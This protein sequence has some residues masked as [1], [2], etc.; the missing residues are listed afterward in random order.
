MSY[1]S[2]EMKRSLKNKRFY[3]AL[4]LNFLCLL[5]SIW[6]MRVTISIDKGYSLFYS[7]ITL[8]SFT[9]ITLLAPVIAALPFSGSFLQD[10]DHQFIRGVFGRMKPSKYYWN[11]IVSTGISGFLAIV[12]PLV[13]LLIIN[14]LIFGNHH[15]NVGSFSGPFSHLYIK[16]QDLAYIICLILN[17]GLFGFVYANL[18]LVTSLFVP[19]T[20]ATIG[21]PLIIYMIP[22]FFFTY[23]G[24][25]RFEP[26]TTFYLSANAYETYL[27]VYGQLLL[28]EIITLG[29]GY[30]RI[31]ETRI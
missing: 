30:I 29:A 23:F 17:S 1:F 22:S 14:I 5:I 19:K 15:A 9:M 27:T 8:G 26:V 20:Y 13:C 28:L 10:T 2:L 3:T 25:D 6:G 16:E 24:L 21:I 11:K 7:A 12:V 18:G 4:L 31:K